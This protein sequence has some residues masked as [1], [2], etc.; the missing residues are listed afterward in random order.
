MTTYLS[1]P[2]ATPSGPAPDYT[3]RTSSSPIETPG[4]PWFCL[5][6]PRPDPIPVFTLSSSDSDAS[7]ASTSST[8]TTP[9]FIS[10]RP[11]RS[12]G[13][14]Y[15]TSPSNTPNDPSTVSPLATTTYRFGPNRP[16]RMRLFS[17]HAAPMS[18]AALHTLLFSK[19]SNTDTHHT[20]SIISDHT[21]HP[22][23]P[24]PE[25]G[26]HEPLEPWDSFLLTSPALLTRTLAFRTRLGTFEWRYASRRERHALSRARGGEDVSSLLVLER[27]VRVATAQNNQ[28]NP[29]SA[30][31]SKSGEEQI[32]TPVAHFVRGRGT[33]T[34]GSGAS[35][36]GNGGRLDVDLRMW[37]HHHHRHGGGDDGD[38]GQ[39]DK[40]EREMA[41]VLVVATCLVMLKREVD[42]RRAQKFAIIAM[43]VS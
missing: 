10:L 19:D 22:E 14:C 12:S 33:R 7:A 38:D 21:P 4:K 9:T 40:V 3:P 43:A 2:A 42:R 18:T 28:N 35:S 25:E 26:E 8:T 41:V 13:S 24:L 30:S 31:A 17:P 37:E 34:E 23:P 1:Y 15:L 36:A 29:S 6:L 20:D 16:A 32:R 39:A 11:E 27:V 5:P